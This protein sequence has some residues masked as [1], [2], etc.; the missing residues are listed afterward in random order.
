MSRRKGVWRE[1]GKP[2]RGSLREAAGIDV[3]IIQAVF[4][5][6]GYETE[7]RAYPWESLFREEKT[8]SSP[9]FQ[10]VERGEVASL[11]FHQA[12]GDGEPQTE[13]L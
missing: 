4:T 13:A 3:E 9:A 11:P 8:K 5:R 2:I 6:L 10:G 7:I 1:A 12:L